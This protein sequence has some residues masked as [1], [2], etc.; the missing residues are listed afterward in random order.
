M[1]EKT[2]KMILLK[3]QDLKDLGIIGKKKKGRRK[4]RRVLKNIQ[5]QQIAQQQNTLEP[6][7][8]VQ[9]SDNR[10]EI[11]ALRNQMLNNGV[12]NNKNTNEQK[13]ILNDLQTQHTY[14]QDATINGFQHFNNK[15]RFL[16]DKPPQDDNYINPRLQGVKQNI[17]FNDLNDNIDTPTTAGSDGFI[18]S[19]TDIPEYI[20]PEEDTD[21]SSQSDYNPSVGSEFFHGFNTSTPI[22]NLQNINET[23]L[24]TDTK[25][26]IN[27][28]Q[29][30]LSQ[31]E[32]DII[33]IKPNR[34]EK[35]KAN[36]LELEH[37]AHNLGIQEPFT[38]NMV[39]LRGIIADKIRLD[40][41]KEAYEGLGGKDEK[42]INSQS[43]NE[44]RA[45]NT[46][47]ANERKKNLNKFTKTVKAR[48]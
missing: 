25:S 17:N 39:A 22:N 2:K 4:K 33:G 27:N 35:N 30:F 18:A 47:L 36:R 42:F 24:K 29:V 40:K 8:T 19:G 45:E 9:T 31:D 13:Q 16:T 32:S 38:H 37:Q 41:L 44:V 23:D 48:P 3:I 15:T 7:K 12:I 26:I 21:F 1:K 28:P 34:G 14:L 11:D 46:R 43:S 5:N 6:S 10:N 20:E